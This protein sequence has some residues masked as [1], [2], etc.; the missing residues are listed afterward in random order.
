MPL[1]LE[2]RP[3]RLLGQHVVDR[4]VLADVAQELEPSSGSS[5]SRLSRMRARSCPARSPGTARAAPR[6]ASKLAATTSALSSSLR[7]AARSDRRSGRCRRRPGR[8]GRCPWRWKR[9]SSQSGTRWP[10]WRLRRRGVEPAVDGQA[11]R[12]R[13]PARPAGPRPRP[14]R[15]ARA[16]GG[17]RAAVAPWW[18]SG[19]STRRGGDARLTY[20][21]DGSRNRHGR[22]TAFEMPMRAVATTP[23]GR[24]GGNSPPACPPARG[25]RPAPARRGRARWRGPG[26]G[27]RPA[28]PVSATPRAAARSHGSAR[29]RRPPAARRRC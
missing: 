21:D 3:H 29:R 19:D 2:A 22:S 4:E 8:S 7:G 13:D 11:L 27:A 15:S 28:A 25:R 10:T 26:A 18:P 9:A 24:S 14:A 1:A 5:Q 16:S 17:R 23:R 12:C 6:I 20:G